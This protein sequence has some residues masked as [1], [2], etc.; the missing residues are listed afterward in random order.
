[1]PLRG[2]QAVALGCCGG[3]GGFGL[4]GGCVWISSSSE[5]EWMEQALGR[6][7]PQSAFFFLSKSLH[8]SW[9]LDLGFDCQSVLRNE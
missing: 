8:S 7:L 9:P 6:Q 1:M 3:R 4:P 5:S 2:R